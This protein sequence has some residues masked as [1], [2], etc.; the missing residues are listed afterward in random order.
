MTADET[1]P[2]ANPTRRLLYVAI[3]CESWTVISVHPLFK[4]LSHTRAVAALIF[5]LHS[6]SAFFYLSVCSLAVSLWALSRYESTLSARC[7]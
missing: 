3:V 5:G 1:R 6:G 4:S 7:Q 2:A